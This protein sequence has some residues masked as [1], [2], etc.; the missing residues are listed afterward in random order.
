MR[1]P[2]SR[3]GMTPCHPGEFI[4]ALGRRLHRQKRGPKPGFKHR[5]AIARARR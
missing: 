3:V 1:K 4:R 5:R 2:V